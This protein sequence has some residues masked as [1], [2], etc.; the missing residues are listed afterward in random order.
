MSGDPSVTPEPVEIAVAVVER[1]GKF[2]IG[3]RPEGVA[4]AGYWEFPGGKLENGESPEAAAVRECREETTLKVRVTGRYCTVD[5][6]YAHGRL[7]LHFI[8]CAAV[9]RPVSMPARFRWVS[10]EE[11]SGY[12]FPPANAQ[13]LSMLMR[14]AAPIDAR[15]KTG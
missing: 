7:R 15:I 14:D 1:D 8:A 11:L 2:L 13:L 6:D 5:H 9:D 12:K 10:R 4:L 3:K